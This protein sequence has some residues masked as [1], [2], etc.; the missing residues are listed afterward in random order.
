M[1]CCCF[2]DLTMQKIW[3]FLD[4]EVE[5]F[6]FMRDRATFKG[7]IGAPLLTLY[8]VFHN[9]Y[10]FDRGADRVPWR[11]PRSGPSSG[12]A[13][14]GGCPIPP[15]EFPDP[16]AA[17]SGSPHLPW[18]RAAGRRPACG[19]NWTDTSGTTAP[20]AEEEDGQ[21]EEDRKKPEL[22]CKI[23]VKA[24]TGP[25]YWGAPICLSSCQSI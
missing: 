6:C 1:S 8:L 7:L 23:S 15:A 19:W 22:F 16:S 25:F 12:P 24:S 2:I 13:D 9:M 17:D 21:G 14:Y 20:C 10:S 11:W 4:L 18:R 3:V 5:I